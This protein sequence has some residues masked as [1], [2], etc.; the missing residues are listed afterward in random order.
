M[1]LTGLLLQSV[2]AGTGVSHLGIETFE[3]GTNLL[4][5]SACFIALSGQCIYLGGQLGFGFIETYLCSIALSLHSRHC[6]VVLLLCALKISVQADSRLLQ[7]SHFTTQLCGLI[8]SLVTRTGHQ[9][10]LVLQSTHG[11]AQQSKFIAGLG[12]RCSGTFKIA[13]QGLYL[14]F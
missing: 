4:N 8:G 2:N 6:S 13:V 3:F 1:Q 11:R 10:Q 5:L 12:I 14:T 7:I 9:A